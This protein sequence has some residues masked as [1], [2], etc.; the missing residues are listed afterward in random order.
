MRH[1]PL[2]RESTRR[3]LIALITLAALAAIG[4]TSATTAQPR[5]PVYFLQGEQL[6]RVDRPG[7]TPFDAVQC[8]S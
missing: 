5:V 3:F 1:T 4:A 8:D 7:S 2:G 6:A